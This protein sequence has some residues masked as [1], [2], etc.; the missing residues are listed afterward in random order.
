MNT[1]RDMTKGSRLWAREM[2]FTALLFL[3][4][5]NLVFAKAPQ[6]SGG[7]IALVGLIA[8]YPAL[9]RERWSLFFRSYSVTVWSLVGIGAYSAILSFFSG[10]WGQTSRL[11]HFLLLSVF[12]AVAWAAVEEGW[13]DSPAESFVRRFAIVATIQSIL[14]FVSLFSPAFRV[15]VSELLVRG[16]NINL[17]SALR[18]S[19]FSNSGGAALSVVQA[20]GVYAAGA[21]ASR[22]RNKAPWLL[23][24]LI[25]GLASAING[26]TGLLMFVA[27]VPISLLAASKARWSL[28]RNVAIGVVL[29]LAVSPFAVTKFRENVPEGDAIITSAEE[30]FVE[31]SGTA[32]WQNLSGM[33][34]PPI[35]DD[36]FAG[37][38]RVGGEY[39]N[40]SGHD[41]GYVQT[42]YALGIPMTALFYCALLSLC[43]GLVLRVEGDGRVLLQWLVLVMFVIEA[44]EPFVFKY[45]LPFF[46][47]ARAWAGT[48]KK[49]PRS[50]VAS[51]VSVGYPVGT[52]I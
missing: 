39:G 33:A 44:K 43:F 14:I 12:G 37:T 26:R 15:L 51:R 8:A 21:T 35:T 20:L 40:P 4:V 9:V 6:L 11:A 17:L 5:Y 10:D 42:Y 30:I 47:F 52:S 31:G 28:T 16:G 45:A 41:S 13:S 48:S 25:C 32:S 3:F 46:I 29:I 18:P 2:L 19:G 36:T 34:I 38:G 50:L 23:S 22:S 1:D 7:R 49:Y 27:A 24:A